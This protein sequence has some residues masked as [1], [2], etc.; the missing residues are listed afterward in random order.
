MP[1]QRNGIMIRKGGVLEKKK[2]Y[3]KG[4]MG[5]NK[6]EKTIGKGGRHT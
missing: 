4:V 2:E 1:R 5:E 6:E 3:S